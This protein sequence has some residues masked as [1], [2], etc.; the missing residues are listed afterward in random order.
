MLVDYSDKDEEK[1]LQLYISR[2]IM[3]RGKSDESHVEKIIRQLMD[4]ALKYTQEGYKKIDLL[5]QTI[6]GKEWALIK[7]SDTGVGIPKDLQ[8]L[9][10]SNFRQ[11]SEGI[12]RKH[13]GV[14]VG[15]SLTRNL[16]N[17]LGGKIEVESEPGKGSSF[18]VYLPVPTEKGLISRTS[19]PAESFGRKPS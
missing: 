6:N 3:N 18:T 2:K 12:N 14:G 10:F 15:L 11:A 4:N 13:E 5:Q 16:V 17:I 1:G 19:L 7:I 9:I 8:G